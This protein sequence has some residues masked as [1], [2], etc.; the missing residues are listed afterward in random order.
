MFEFY[1]TYIMYL[2]ATAGLCQCKKASLHI[3][4]NHSY[5]IYGFF[6][7][8]HIEMTPRDF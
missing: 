5:I 8:H 2:H 1:L 7:Q 4:A 3:C 6:P